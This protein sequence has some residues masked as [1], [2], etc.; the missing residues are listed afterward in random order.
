ML[1]HRPIREVNGKQ[2][3]NDVMEIPNFS[4]YHNFEF[5]P[6]GIRV[7]K[8]YSVGEGK[9]VNYTNIVRKRQGPTLVVVRYSKFFRIFLLRNV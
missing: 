5:K 3:S 2:K 1:V 4:A 6:R 9:T 8:A 7:S